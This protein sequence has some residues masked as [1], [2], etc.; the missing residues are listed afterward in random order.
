MLKHQKFQISI[1]SISNDP[2]KIPDDGQSE[3]HF[4]YCQSYGQNTVKNYKMAK[5]RILQGFL[6]YNFGSY[7]YFLKRILLDLF[8][9]LFTWFV[10]VSAP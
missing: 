7:Q 8:I 10:G 1:F 4:E 5:L 2:P 6:G 3:I 9:T